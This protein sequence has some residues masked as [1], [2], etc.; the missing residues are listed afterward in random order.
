M[1]T[2]QTFTQPKASGK[3]KSRKTKCYLKILS[4]GFVANA[5][6]RSVR[7]CCIVGFVAILG[8]RDDG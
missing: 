3:R 2:K 8:G 4:L 5:S 6:P 7:I 1:Q